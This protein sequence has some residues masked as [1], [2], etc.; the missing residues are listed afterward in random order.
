MATLKVIAPLM[1]AAMHY[2]LTFG[3]RLAVLFSTI[4]YHAS[5]IG[6][7]VQRATNP[8]YANP[9][10]VGGG[11]QIPLLPTRTIYTYGRK[12]RICI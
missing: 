9:Q 2:R 7:N 10:R 1:R 12:N 11:V 3:K 5:V 4:C 8:R 6:T